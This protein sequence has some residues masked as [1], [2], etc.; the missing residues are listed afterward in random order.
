MYWKTSVLMIMPEEDSWKSLNE[1]IP[2]LFGVFPLKPTVC[3]VP[4]R[5]LVG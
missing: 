4:E 2:M 5:Q 1:N 3:S